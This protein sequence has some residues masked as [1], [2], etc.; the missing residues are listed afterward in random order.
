MR[1]DQEDAKD[2]AAAAAAVSATAA[3]ATAAAAAADADVRVLELVEDVV[4]RW[5]STYSMVE[6]VLK[7]WD[8]FTTAILHPAFTMSPAGPEQDANQRQ[9]RRLKI[10]FTDEAAHD[11]LKTIVAC[12]KPAYVLT[13]RLQ[14]QSYPTIV[15]VG[16]LVH[17]AVEGLRKINLPLAAKLCDALAD[18]F[19]NWS[20]PFIPVRAALLHPKYA[21]LAYI[22]L[23]RRGEVR[24]Q[25]LAAL[26]E[27]LPF[28]CKHDEDSIITEESFFSMCRE[29]LRSI[30]T[31]LTEDRY[32][33]MSLQ[34]FWSSQR[35]SFPGSL[36]LPLVA[37]YLSIPATSAPSE[38]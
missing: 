34:E 23:N 1:L 31:R 28:F 30:T 21:S 37:G 13:Q 20:E 15:E 18:R 38:R 11:R 4:T 5:N 25:A 22:P 26:E 19:R 7:V 2:A 17:A 3:T 8:A 6:R 36:L 27:E 24:A 33:A 12:L 35:D 9:R 32:S 14:G 29:A 10:M 16:P